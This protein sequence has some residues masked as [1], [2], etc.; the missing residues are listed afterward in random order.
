MFEALV[1]PN[2]N[3][4]SVNLIGG[5]GLYGSP[6][7]LRLIYGK[8][9]SVCC[10]IGFSRHSRH[11]S[12]TKSQ[13]H[14]LSMPLELR[15]LIEHVPQV[16]KIVWIGLRPSRRADVLSVE[17]A[18]IT[19][20][21]SLVGDHFGG[22]ANSKRQITLIQAEHLDVVARMLGRDTIAPELV[23]RNIVVAGINLLSLKDRQFQIG[24][25]ILHTT[26]NCQPCSRMEENLGSGG[27]SAMRGHGGVTARVVQG[28][29]IRIG[30]SV[31]VL[32]KT[33][34]PAS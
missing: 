28:G 22:P 6:N 29:A 20:D 9:N 33:H 17:Q 13:F 32:S 27:Y 15:E 14:E 21:E 18:M 24:D 1:L 30:D 12:Q 23:R 34:S 26:G 5:L 16:G 31:R 4:A 7:A 10:L 8:L 2:C 11:R 19:I 25:A 3:C